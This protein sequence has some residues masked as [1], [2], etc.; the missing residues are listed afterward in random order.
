MVKPL[1]PTDAYL[2]SPD[3][4]RIMI[5]N[6]KYKWKMLKAK[7]TFMALNADSKFECERNNDTSDNQ[8]EK[9]SDSSAK[10]IKS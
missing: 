6:D 1:F 7:K 4:K 9:D 2:S 10:I 5:P 3:F 8:H